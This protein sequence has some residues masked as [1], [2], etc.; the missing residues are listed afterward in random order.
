M[1]ILHKKNIDVIAYEYWFLKAGGNHATKNEAKL[2]L[3]KL[4]W[5]WTYTSLTNIW[6]KTNTKRALLNGIYIVLKI[7]T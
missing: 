3:I 5:K 4:F 1:K 7:I 6:S 2:F